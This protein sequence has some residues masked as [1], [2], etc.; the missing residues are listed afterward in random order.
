MGG[1]GGER[2]LVSKEDLWG[3]ISSAIPPRCNQTVEHNQNREDLEIFTAY[4]ANDAPPITSSTSPIS[5]FVEL[6]IAAE[7]LFKFKENN[8]EG[9]FL[10]HPKISLKIKL[11]CS[12][13]KTL[14]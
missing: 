8:V 2:I 7:T 5:N 3:L 11:L 10:K 6:G 14:K 4:T 9:D 1:G 12:F 13:S